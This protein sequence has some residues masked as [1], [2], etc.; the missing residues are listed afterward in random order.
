MTLSCESIKKSLQQIAGQFFVVFAI[1]SS[2]PVSIFNKNSTSLRQVYLQIKHLSLLLNSITALVRLQCTQLL[3]T[4]AILP[5][6][7]VAC[8]LH[9]FE[10]QQEL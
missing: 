9:S 6:L 3:G 7:E 1:F 8:D 4:S 2:F 5:M 10:A